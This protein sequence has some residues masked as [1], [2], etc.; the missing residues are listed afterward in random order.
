MRASMKHGPRHHDALKRALASDASVVPASKAWRELARDFEVGR[1]TSK[2][3]ALTVDDR[4]KL[5]LIG[6]ALWGFDPLFGR[7]TGDRL[8]VAKTATD[9]KIASE[10]PDASYVLAKGI[11]GF[12]LPAGASARVRIEA[13]PID[14]VEAVVVVENLDC[15]DAWSGEG[16]DLAGRTLFLYRGHDRVAKGVKRLLQSLPD[17]IPVLVFPDFDPAG[18][19]IAISTPRAS[20]VIAPADL[21][22]LTPFHGHADYLAQISAVA[23]VSSAPPPGI[24]VLWAAMRTNGISCKQQHIIARGLAIRA[25]ALD[26][27][28]RTAG[29]EAEKREEAKDSAEG[30]S[31]GEGS[32]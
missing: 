29:E 13:L 8:G 6:K 4:A 9:D 31:S 7:P 12:A 3:I 25:Y 23:H 27:V 32:A 18:L 21:D 24:A 22:G 16:L 1:E 26:R 30:A 14:A 10:A 2:G 11:V 17:G 20:H 28:S 5:R 15:F 19:L